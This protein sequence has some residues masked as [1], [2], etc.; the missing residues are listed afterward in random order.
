MSQA[1]EFLDRTMK[2]AL[3]ALGADP[4]PIYTFAFYHDHESATVSV[5]V[6]TKESSDRLIARRKKFAMKQLPKQV[7]KGNLEHA[8]LF[9]VQTGHSTGLGDFARK[10]LA[11]A[12]IPG[13]L[14]NDDRIPADA[15]AFCAAMFEA[16]VAHQDEILALAPDPDDVIFCC[17]LE[18]AEVG[19]VWAAV[20]KE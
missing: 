1:T 8:K 13:G 10:N 18:D 14:L 5:C 16:V 7:R 6:D 19:L 11:R 9:N 3:E 17:S 4:L 15:T 2:V 12:K 20:P